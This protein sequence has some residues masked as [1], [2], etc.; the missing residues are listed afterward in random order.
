MIAEM[1]GNDTVKITK[2]FS[3]TNLSQ[4]LFKNW[5]SRSIITWQDTLTENPNTIQRLYNNFGIKGFTDTLLIMP[6]ELVQQT[7]NNLRNNEFIY[8]DYLYVAKNGF[9]RREIVFKNK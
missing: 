8:I 4:E 7:A 6:G 9:T 3:N 1:K 2:T 5:S